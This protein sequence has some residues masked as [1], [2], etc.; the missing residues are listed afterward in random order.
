MKTSQPSPSDRHAPELRKQ[1]ELREMIRIY[2][3]YREE[4]AY[5]LAM[6]MKSH[7]LDI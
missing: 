2:A 5:V 3:K 7:P 1:A 6:T 4:A